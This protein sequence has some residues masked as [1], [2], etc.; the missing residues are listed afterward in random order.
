MSVVPN[1]I[2]TYGAANMPEADGV[3]TGGAVDFTKRVAWYDLSASDTIDAVSTSGSDT[4]V[5]VQVLA[6]N[7]GGSIVTSTVAALTGTTP[8]TNV[9]AL[10]TV[11][12]LLAAVTT[13]GAI[14]SLTDPGG[15]TAVG[16][17]AVYRHTPVIAS[18]T[19]RTGSAN[20][21]GSTPPIF[22]GTPVPLFIAVDQGR[23]LASPAQ[24]RV[25]KTPGQGRILVMPVRARIL[26]Q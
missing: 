6:R 18:H 21:T 16:D 5:N 10:G 1:E 14:A 24:I 3:T 12:R 17:V 11:E 4:A 7:A 8:I 26:K 22:A 9:G 19:A 25:V 20:T 15:T 23:L 2:V 13:G